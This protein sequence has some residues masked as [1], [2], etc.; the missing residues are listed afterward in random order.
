MA[1]D[2]VRH[3]VVLFGGID[4]GNV[5]FSDLWEWDGFEWTQRLPLDVP[6][7]RH[8]ANLV[9]DV[10][11]QVFVLVGGT[12]TYYDMWELRFP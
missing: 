4:G 5:T 8:S 11:R 7:G 10:H 1:Y 3:R 9:Y 12:Y 6:R 2:P